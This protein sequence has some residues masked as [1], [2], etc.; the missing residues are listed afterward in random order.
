MG[1]ADGASVANAQADAAHRLTYFERIL[2]GHIIAGEYRT[3]T[4]K[5]LAL[6]QPPDRRAP[7]VRWRGRISTTHL[8]ISD[9]N[10]VPRLA[11]TSSATFSTSRPRSGTLR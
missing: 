2:V 7:L 10:A 4:A 6:H 1:A 9:A 11:A 8:P 5:G 3:A